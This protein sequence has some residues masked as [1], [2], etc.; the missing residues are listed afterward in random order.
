M[1]SLED[2]LWRSAKASGA[3]TAARLVKATATD[4]VI[5][6]AASG[7]DKVIGAAGQKVGIADAKTGDYIA[8]GMSRVCFGGA[9]A[10]GDPIA[11]DATGKAV[12]AGFGDQVAGYALEAGVSGDEGLVFIA[13]SPTGMMKVV[14]A[15][16]AFAANDS[17]LPAGSVEHEGVYTVPATAGAS[18]VTLPAGAEDNTRIHVIANGTLNGHTV[19][20]RD[21]TGPVNLTAALTASKRHMQSFVKLSGAWYPAG[22]A[23]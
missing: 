13:P 15:L 7:K 5:A 9:V 8:F 18:T 17:V 16:P 19:Q 11:S 23:P 4:G 21:A 10:F 3:I 6:Q 1:S 2:G 12:K 20:Y 14:G 22:V